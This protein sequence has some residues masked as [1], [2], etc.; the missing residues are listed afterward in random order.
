[1]PELTKKSI[2]I[3]I[4]LII[5]VGFGIAYAVHKSIIA[6]KKTAKQAEVETSLVALHSDGDD[7]TMRIAG[8]CS[9]TA[10]PLGRN[11]CKELAFSV[12]K[13]D[14]E[15]SAIKKQVVDALE[16]NDWTAYP[17][18]VSG[19]TFFKEKMRTENNVVAEARAYKSDYNPQAEAPNMHLVIFDD[20]VNFK[21]EIFNDIPDEDVAVEKTIAEGEYIIVTKIGSPYSGDYSIFSA[22]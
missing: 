12:Y 2:F 10:E 5:T 4:I 3:V 18:L 7:Y 20:E 9:K 15:P 21:H 13:T 1:M 17:G 16:A 11:S 19:K 6:D 22:N 8:Q 14:K